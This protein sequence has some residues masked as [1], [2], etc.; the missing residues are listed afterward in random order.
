MSAW[1]SH[2]GLQIV[3]EDYFTG[4]VRTVLMTL[5]RLAHVF[6]S[7]LMILA[8]LRVAFGSFA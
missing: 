1:H 8:E 4:G 5:S 3:L 2:L 6:L 7:I